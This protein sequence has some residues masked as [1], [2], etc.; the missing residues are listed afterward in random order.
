[1]KKTKRLCSLLLAVL[2]LCLLFSIPSYAALPDD[3]VVVPMWDNIFSI[4]SNMGFGTNPASAYGQ[5]VKKSASD[6]IEATITVY[7]NVGGDWFVVSSAYNS[8]TEMTMIVYTEFAAV[9]GAE[10]KAVLNVT[11]YK[12]GIGESVEKTIYRTCPSN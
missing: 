11:V 6:L 10:Y 7:I 9:P 12:N 1:M 5:I 8:T 2:S 3:D 4:S